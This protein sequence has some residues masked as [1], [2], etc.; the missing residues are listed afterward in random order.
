MQVFPEAPAGD[1]LV[2]H[3]GEVPQLPPHQ[4]REQ[5]PGVGRADRPRVLGRRQELEPI[6]LACPDEALKLLS[7]GRKELANGIDILDPAKS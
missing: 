3:R 6:G 7:G 4:P 2:V 5:A 1:V